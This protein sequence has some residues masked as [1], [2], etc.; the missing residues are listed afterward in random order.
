MKSLIQKCVFNIF[1]F[2]IHIIQKVS[3]FLYIYIYIYG[4]AAVFL[5]ENSEAYDH[6]D[7]T[8]CSNLKLPLEEG[9]LHI[10]CDVPSSS[11]ECSV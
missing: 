4:K 2:T 9:V 1:V 6:L 5:F 7:E 8:E 3:K 11:T 10:T